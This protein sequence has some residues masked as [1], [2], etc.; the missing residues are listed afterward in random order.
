MGSG[1]WDTVA[2][3]AA[4]TMRSVKGIADFD[5]S[6]KTAAQPVAK[7]K[8]HPDLDPADL[9]GGKVRES[10]DNT[11]HPLSTAI[12][13]LF[14]VTGSMVS[15][16]MQLQQRLP[17][18]LETLLLAGHIDDPQI[19]VGAIGDGYADQVPLQVGQFESDNRIDEQLRN[20]FLERGGGGGMEESY[21]LALYFAARQTALDCLEKRGKKG[22]LFMIGDECPYSVLRS[23]V[24]KKAYGKDLI[25][26][27]AIPVET[28]V[29]EVKKKFNFFFITPKQTSNYGKAALVSRWE[30]LIGPNYIQIDD[31]DLVVETISTLIGLTE[32]TADL[33]GAPSSLRLA[34]SAYA[35]SV[36]PVPKPSDPDGDTVRI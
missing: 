6:A 28:L 33:A 18:L 4:T 11:E 16:P 21:E 30:T 26:D 13:V 20:I 29:D 36:V 12:S 8:A 7:R 5:Y 31:P 35:A 19:L 27:E 34:V 23:E 32:G 22:Y 24:V 1:R 15:V 25:N 9:A 10:R 14:D 2:Y 3:N 17:D